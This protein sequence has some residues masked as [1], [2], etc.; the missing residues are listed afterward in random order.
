MQFDSFAFYRFLMEKQRQNVYSWIIL[1]S[2][3]MVWGSSFILIKKALLYFSAV[4]VGILRVTISFIVLLPFAFSLLKTISKKMTGYLI[5]SGFIGSFSPALFFA[6]AQTKIDSAVAGTLNALTPLFT[7]ILGV[8]FF[9]FKTRWY[10]VLGVAIGLAGALGLIYASSIGSFELNFG[11]S[12]LIIVST[13]CYAFNV[14]WIKVYLKELNSFTITVFTFFYIG[15]PSIIWVIFFSEI[16]SKLYSKPETLIG[17]GYLSILAVVGTVIALIAFN[18]LIKVSSPIFAS[19]VTYMIPVVAI[20]W[21]VV[22]GEVFKASYVIWFLL[23]IGGV[24]LVNASPARIH[25]IGSRI[26][27]KRKTG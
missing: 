12:L 22:D 10:N 2:L 16:P 4:E 24:L 3:V 11:Y 23:I 15:I 6:L 14:N 9:K 17:I 26:F 25:N 5:L 20:I 27:F 7:L 13:I 18:R 8:S 21:G 19:S 1:L